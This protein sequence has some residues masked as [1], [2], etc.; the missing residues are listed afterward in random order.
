MLN[1]EKSWMPEGS[2]F[3]NSLNPIKVKSGL[4]VFEN[5]FNMIGISFVKSCF[6]RS[7]RVALNLPRCHVRIID[8]I[9]SVS[10]NPKD[11]APY[12]HNFADKPHCRK[13]HCGE[14]LS[15]HGDHKNRPLAGAWK[16]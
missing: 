6:A 14:S 12:C 7:L 1:N 2:L 4:S 9:F 11:A 5:V 15:E 16:L 3:K 10:R 13:Q 8:E